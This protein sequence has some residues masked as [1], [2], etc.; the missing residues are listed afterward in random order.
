[1]NTTAQ[2]NRGDR[3]AWSV[4]RWAAAQPRLTTFIASPAA[5]AG[6]RLAQEQLG[7]KLALWGHG[8]A[9]DPHGEVALFERAYLFNRRP[10]ARL[11]LQQVLETLSRGTRLLATPAQVDGY[12]NANLSVIGS[13]KSPKAALVGT[14]GLPDATEIHFVIPTHTSRQLVERVD[15]V[16]TC[17]ANRRTPPYLFTELGVLRW[18][19]HE[20]AWR[21]LERQPGISVQDVQ[22]RSGFRVLADAA[23]PELPELPDA[24]LDGL[25]RV[26]PRRI[27]DLEF[28]S[29]A[30]ARQQ[31]QME[32]EAAERAAADE[33]Q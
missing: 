14:R 33:Q 19:P 30:A 16:S 17:A 13:W 1:M 25:A 21:L 7:A 9:Y 28:V 26:D 27:R 15:F 5:L 6:V 23:V 29:S 24:M 2:E 12:G 3:L 8:G 20:S 22:R 4:A 11:S 10:R 18:S 31:R 32:I